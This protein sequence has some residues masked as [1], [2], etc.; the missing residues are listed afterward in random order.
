MYI[1]KWN[2]F[3]CWE[4]ERSLSIEMKMNCGSDTLAHE[5]VTEKCDST[6]V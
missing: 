6:F 2:L 4:D 5:N 1:H 3:S